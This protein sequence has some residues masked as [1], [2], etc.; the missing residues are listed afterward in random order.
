MGTLPSGKRCDGFVIDFS[1]PK[2]L[3]LPAPASASISLMA[4]V[5]DALMVI[6]IF[7]FNE[8]IEELNFIY[9]SLEH[10]ITVC[11]NINKDSPNYK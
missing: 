7:M 5:P 4:S 6:L 11:I 1:Q 9:I 2:P 10:N 3:G 8:L